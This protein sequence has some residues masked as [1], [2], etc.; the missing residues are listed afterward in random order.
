MSIL[1]A[2]ASAKWVIVSIDGGGAELVE[3]GVTGS[4]VAPDE[5]A[6]A[7]ALTRA[8]AGLLQCVSSERLDAWRERF[9]ADAVGRATMDLYD[10]CL[11]SQWQEHAG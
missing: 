10:K 3:E 6:L 1:E 11:R 7:Q 2:I 8:A 4:V 5:D 9:S